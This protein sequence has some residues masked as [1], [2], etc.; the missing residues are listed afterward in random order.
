MLDGLASLLHDKMGQSAEAEVLF[1]RG[2]RIRQAE[3]GN[4][5]QHSPPMTKWNADILEVLIGQIRECGNIDFVIRKAFR[6]LGHPEL[7]KPDR[8]FL[9]RF[10]RHPEMNR[11]WDMMEAGTSSSDMWTWIAGVAFMFVLVGLIIYGGTSTQTT[12]ND[13]NPP[14]T[15]TTGQAR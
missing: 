15:T 14:A 2:L 1:G 13:V 7:L 9:H 3:F 4:S 12:R 5:R 8:D 10:D 11:R 6:I